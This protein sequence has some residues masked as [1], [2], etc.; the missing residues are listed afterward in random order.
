MTNLK[1]RA[2]LDQVATYIEEKACQKVEP[3]AVASYRWSPA[4][5]RTR[6]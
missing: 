4:R 2:G 5:N 3:E 1:T 6:I